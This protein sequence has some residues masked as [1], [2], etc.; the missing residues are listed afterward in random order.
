MPWNAIPISLTLMENP[1]LQNPRD[2]E[3]ADRA[4]IMIAPFPEPPDFLPDGQPDRMLLSVIKAL[5]PAMISQMR[6]KP[7]QRL[8][9]PVDSTAIV[10]VV[11]QLAY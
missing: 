5:V 11:F 3:D 2:G 6:F 8:G 4:V 9:T 1:P 7:A 10:H